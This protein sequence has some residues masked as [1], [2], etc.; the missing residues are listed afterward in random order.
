MKKGPQFHRSSDHLPDRKLRNPS[1]KKTTGQVGEGKPDDLSKLEVTNVPN[2]HD[3]KV[4]TALEMEMC[5]KTMTINSRFP[6][7]KSKSLL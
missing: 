4:N 3:A 5:A 1:G 2:A 6:K 7:P